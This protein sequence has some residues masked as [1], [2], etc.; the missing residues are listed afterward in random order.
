MVY[1][2]LIDPSA[3]S[4]DPDKFGSLGY[5]IYA[6]NGFV[7]SKGELPTTYRG[8]IYPFCIAIISLITFGYNIWAIQLFQILLHAG[9][10]LIVYLIARDLFDQ[11]SALLAS[12]IFAIHPTFVYFLPKIWIETLLTFLIILSVLIFIRYLKKPSLYKAIELGVSLGLSALT[13]S[14]VLMLPIIIGIVVYLVIKDKI[15]ALAHAFII[16]MA[17]IIVIIP[18]TIRNYNVTHKFI[19]IH[20]NASINFIIGDSLVKNIFEF[21]LS[22]SILFAKGHEEVVY[23]LDKYNLSNSH[24]SKVEAELIREVFKRMRNHPFFYLKKVVVQAFTFWYLGE[25]P[26]KTLL[27][28]ITT[29]PFVILGFIC[30]V[31]ELSRKPDIS[32][33]SPFIFVAYFWFLCSLV[34]SIA[35]FSTPILPIVIIFAAHFIILKTSRRDIRMNP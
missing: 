10:C 4:V 34:Y 20:T 11:E 7:Y 28:I 30:G 29:L 16:M 14:I 33:A 1:P 17:A 8:P 32:K 12:L 19:P 15:R 5:N 21:P 27:I 23:L 2:K 25:T 35:R 31:S 24:D 9:T 18:W 3:V 6:N 26:I 13:K 22:H